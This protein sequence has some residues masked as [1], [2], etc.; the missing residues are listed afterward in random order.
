MFEVLDAVS[1]SGWMNS[2][3]CPLQYACLD[4]AASG[5]KPV[6][7]PKLLDSLSSAVRQSNSSMWTIKHAPLKASARR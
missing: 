1:C 7:M 2:R 4:H 5:G 6:L 3:A